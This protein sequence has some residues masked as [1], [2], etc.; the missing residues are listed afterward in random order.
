M[1]EVIQIPD[2]QRGYAESRKMQSVEQ[3]SLMLEVQ[4]LRAV[5][6]EQQKKYDSFSAKTEQTIL[7]VCF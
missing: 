4:H 7:E 2:V 1:G 6:G 5:V 3:A